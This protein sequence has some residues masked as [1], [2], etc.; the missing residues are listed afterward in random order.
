[1]TASP[2]GPA[3]LGP[4]VVWGCRRGRC[5]PDPSSCTDAPVVTDWSGPG[6]GRRRSTVVAASAQ[7][8]EDLE[9]RPAR[10]SGSI[11]LTEVTVT[12]RLVVVLVGKVTVVA[13]PSLLRVG[14]LT[15]VPSLNVSVPTG[16]LIVRVGSVV[17]HYL[18]DG[19]RGAPGELEPAARRHR[20]RSPILWWSRRD[21]RR[22]RRRLPWRRS[23]PSRCPAR[24]RSPWPGARC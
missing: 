22:S 24:T 6:I 15:V 4:F 23:G 5:C 13:E 9:S 1:M 20:R 17:Q 8:R 16:D 10:C 2:F 19:L 12:K 21:S 18:V 14:T 7:W 3:G 11:E